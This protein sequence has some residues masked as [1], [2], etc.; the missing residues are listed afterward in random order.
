MPPL[1]SGLRLLAVVSAWLAACS[2]HAAELTVSAASS[3]TNAL[4]D[5]VP[6][7]EAA[8]AGTRVN[9]NLGASGA[10][11]AQMTRGAP[12]DVF[13][14]ADAETMDQAQARGLVRAAQRRELVANTLVVVVPGA[15]GDLGAFGASRASGASDRPGPAGMTPA[16]V[17]TSSAS[18]ASSGPNRSSAPR[19]LADLTRPGYARIAIGLP[20]SVPAGRYTQ[21]ALEAAQL[22]GALKPRMIGAQTVRQAL[23]YVAR[24]EAD[25]GFVYATD[26][27]LMPGKVR[28][29]FTVPTAKPILYPVAPLAASSSP[30]A[31]ARFVEFLFTPA[32]QAVFARHGFSRP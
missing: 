28:V 11:L 21:A 2:T 14:S 5:V 1:S 10:L 19:T 29:A 4:R 31:A 15:S 26:A 27:A 23:D 17:G 3:L 30:Q 12:V 24:G 22:W 32:A 16:P 20:A 13:V 7:F 8:H 9:L 25:A 18:S 6:L